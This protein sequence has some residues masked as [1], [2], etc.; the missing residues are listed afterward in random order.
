MISQGASYCQ[1][2]PFGMLKGLPRNKISSYPSAA[3]DFDRVDTDLNLH[4][5]IVDR[6]GWSLNLKRGF[7]GGRLSRRWLCGGSITTKQAFTLP[8]AS[9][10][11]IR[12]DFESLSILPDMPSVHVSVKRLSHIQCILPVFRHSGRII[13]V[14]L[15]HGSKSR[16]THAFIHLDGVFITLPHEEIDKPGILLIACLLQ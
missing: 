11:I 1:M 8:Q 10:H 5:E 12:I 9:K 2:K 4:Q 7:V 15:D 16:V 13:R 3:R 6:V 14:V